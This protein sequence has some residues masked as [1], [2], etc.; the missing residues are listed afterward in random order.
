[1]VIKVKQED[2]LNQLEELVYVYD[3]QT[4]RLLYSNSSAQRLQMCSRP[5]QSHKCAGSGPEQPLS[6]QQFRVRQVTNRRNG[7]C[8][9]LKE[10]RIDYQGRPACLQVAVD[11]TQRESVSRQIQEKLRQEETLVE[12]I[13][14]LIAAD[15]IED[16]IHSVLRELCRY[17]QADWAFILELN[18]CRSRGTI[19][20]QW[21]ENPRFHPSISNQEYSLSNL[22]L[23][24]CVAPGSSAVLTAENPAIQRES[25]AQALWMRRHNIRHLMAAPFLLQDRELGYVAVANTCSGRRDPSLLESVSYFVINE[26]QKRRLYQ[27]LSYQSTHDAM[28]GI[29][30]RL[31]YDR[32]LEQNPQL[33]SAGVV[34]CDINGLKGINDCKGHAAGDAAIC[35]T[36]QILRECF[37]KGKLFRLGGDEFILLCENAS[38]QEFEHMAAAARQR[39]HKNGRERVALGTVWQRAP[40]DLEELC[41]RADEY[42]YQEKQRYYQAMAQRENPDH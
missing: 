36:A 10:K 23:W 37:H 5:H 3:L 42:M 19:T 27:Q 18:E 33:H 20:F 39:L 26:L 11:I 12:C 17:Y 8:Y 34:F 21:C 1:M 31:E 14:R 13:R 29:Y 4:N 7:R 15:G 41:R 25:P 22:P 6:S 32:Y 38:R 16:G 40:L 2:L 35:Q 28:T 30:N 24:N 9:L